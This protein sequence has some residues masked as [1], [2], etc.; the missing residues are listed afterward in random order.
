LAATESAERTVLAASVPLERRGT[1]Y[2]WFH[3]L[4]GLAALPGALLFGSLWQNQGSRVALTAAAILAG[5]ACV[6]AAM[7]SRGVATRAP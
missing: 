5:L 3:L 4:T 6:A 1:A 7:I 2:G